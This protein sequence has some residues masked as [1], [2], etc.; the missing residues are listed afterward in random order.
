MLLQTVIVGASVGTKLGAA[1]TGAKLGA[2]VTGAKLGTGGVVG[3]VLGTAAVEGAGLGAAEELGLAVDGG[4]LGALV[5][6]WVRQAHTPL[7]D[8][9]S[10]SQITLG[11]SPFK[12]NSRSSLH[13]V[14][15]PPETGTTSA[16]LLHRR[17][18]GYGPAP[19]TGVISILMMMMMKMGRRRLTLL[20]SRRSRMLGRFDSCFIVVVVV[21]ISIMR[22]SNKI[23][24]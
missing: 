23:N 3:V 21:R 24:K 17:Q 19:C 11:I 4:G 22:G 10:E 9:G 20:Q 18:T 12:P 6:C 13:V 1:V 8:T 14:S 2:A 7:S 5:G 15:G 16:P